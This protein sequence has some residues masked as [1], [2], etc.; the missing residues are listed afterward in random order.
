[1]TQK[2]LVYVVLA[3]AVGYIL[4]SAVPQQVAMYTTPQQMITRGGE[5]VEFKTGEVPEH[6]GTLGEPDS[7]P[8]IGVLGEPEALRQPSFLEVSRL[9]ELIKWWT[10]DVI[11]AVAIYWFA[12]QRLA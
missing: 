5:D 12:R 1:M 2:S 4:V 10:V 6:G 3:V 9:P 11:I 7:T 8:D